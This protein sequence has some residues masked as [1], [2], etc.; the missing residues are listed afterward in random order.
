VRLIFLADHT[1]ERVARFVPGAGVTTS[2]HSATHVDHSVIGDV[3]SQIQES[4]VIVASGAHIY[5]DFGGLA[6]GDPDTQDWFLEVTGAHTMLGVS[7]IAHAQ[8]TGRDGTP[9]ARLALENARPNPF[10]S[11][12]SVQFSL[13]SRA[14]ARLEVFDLSGRR[15]G[16]LASGTFDAGVHVIPFDRHDAK[17]SRLPAGVYLYRLSTLGSRLERKFVLLP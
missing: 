12:T 3:T 7:G 13:P 15:I 9:G 10:S 5:A 1:L 14:S 17:G 16:V 4:G 8:A 2:I 6:P 11:Q